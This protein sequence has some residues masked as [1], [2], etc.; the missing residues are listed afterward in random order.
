M[1]Y[2]LSAKLLPPSG[3]GET[4]VAEA[5]KEVFVLPTEDGCGVDG[6]SAAEARAALEKEEESAVGHHSPGTGRWMQIGRSPFSNHM[7]YGL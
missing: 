7:T 3:Q 6:A 1:T 4:Q 5:K 2:T